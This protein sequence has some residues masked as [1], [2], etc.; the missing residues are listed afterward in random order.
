MK[1]PAELVL[2]VRGMV[3]PVSPVASGDVL[4]SCGVPWFVGASPQ[5]LPPPSRGVL[6]TCLS[7]STCL[8]VLY[9]IGHMSCWIAGSEPPHSPVVS[10]NPN[11]SYLQRFHFQISPHS[12]T[13]RVGIS[14]S[15]S[16]GGQSST[17]DNENPHNTWWL[18]TAPTCYIWLMSRGFGWVQRGTSFCLQWAHSFRSF[19]GC[20]LAVSWK[21]T[22]AGPQV[23]R[24][25]ADWPWLCHAETGQVL[26][27]EKQWGKHFGGLGLARAK[28][29]F[30]KATHRR[31]QILECG[32]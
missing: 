24:H 11:Q 29:R 18:Q 6:H 7:M 32:R 19:W 8:S 10:P 21:R 12:E 22:P 1:R 13:Q 17:Q 20:R 15:K 9:R 16:A 31:V 27:R 23:L 4:L 14:T 28:H 3:C 26:Q 30:W 2:S 5:S 25:P